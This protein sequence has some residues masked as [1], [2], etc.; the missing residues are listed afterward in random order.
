MARSADSTPGF[1]SFM[2]AVSNEK[3]EVLI[4]YF[5]SLIKRRQILGSYYCAWATAVVLRQ[6]IATGR[7]S[8]TARLLERVRDVGRRLVQ[9]NPRELAIG[10]IVRRVLGLI[11]DEED[12]QRGGSD[13]AP[14]SQPTSEPATPRGE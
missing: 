11:R 9:A 10:N 14:S 5:I 13:S 1:A 8:N 2:R 6:V 7:A 4:E 3:T 12:E